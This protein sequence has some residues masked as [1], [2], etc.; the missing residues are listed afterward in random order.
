M[1]AP[2]ACTEDAR[3]QGCTCRLS[4]VNSASIDPPEPVTDPWCPLHGYRDADREYQEIKDEG[5]RQN[6]GTDDGF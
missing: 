2:D 4:S 6:C 1:S 3:D 5:P